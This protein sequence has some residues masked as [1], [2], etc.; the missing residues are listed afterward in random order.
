MRRIEFSLDP[1]SGQLISRLDSEFAWPILNY[2]KI[3]KDGNF[4]AALTYTLE[5]IEAVHISIND[6]RALISVGPGKLTVAQKNPHRKFWGFKPLKEK[7]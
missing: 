7:A 4:T 5:K 3:G 2:E 1:R 6:Y